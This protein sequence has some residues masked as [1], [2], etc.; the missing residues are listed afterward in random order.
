MTDISAAGTPEPP[1][2]SPGSVAEGRLQLLAAILLGIAATL[3]AVSAYQASLSDG[4]ALDSYTKSN[5]ALSDA[6]YFYSQGNQT[7]AGDQQLFVQ[8]ATA[9]QTG[10]EDLTSYLTTLMRPELADAVTWWQQDP[11]ALT[12]FDESD[13]NPYVIAEFDEADAK[14]AEAAKLYKAGATEGD[15]G[16]EFQLSTVLLALTLFFGG[17]ATL[18]RR[19]ATAVGLLGVSTIAL[20]AGCLQLA[21][22][23][24]A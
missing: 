4:K 5:A 23:F 1:T 11:D 15:R 18:F 3:T 6:N 13:A 24:A 21:G 9:G 22:A 17:I 20:A 16:D 12:P 7:Y 8:Y 19:R 10:N 2:E 14:S